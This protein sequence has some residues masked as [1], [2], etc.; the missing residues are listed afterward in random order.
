MFLYL[1]TFHYLQVLLCIAQTRLLINS[2]V[3]IGSNNIRFDSL[4]GAKLKAKR[5]SNN[6]P[7]V[8]PFYIYQRGNHHLFWIIY[9]NQWSVCIFTQSYDSTGYLDCMANKVIYDLWKGNE[10]KSTHVVF[11]F[12]LIILL[13]R[14]ESFILL[15]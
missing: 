13:F 12:Q 10:L 6:K 9:L 7:S 5:N 3:W 14:S 4:H 11:I 1:A 2:F 15:F 8:C